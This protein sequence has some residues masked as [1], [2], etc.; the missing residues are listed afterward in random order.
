[1]GALSPTGPKPLVEFTLRD[2]TT[3]NERVVEARDRLQNSVM[4]SPRPPEL[5]PQ[6]EPA[7]R[8]S[9]TE[10]VGKNIDIVA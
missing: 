9:G 6:G 2:R 4:A 7:S 8:S 10:G 1:M 3:S 5:G